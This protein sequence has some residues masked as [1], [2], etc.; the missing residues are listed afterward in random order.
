LKRYPQSILIHATIKRIG[1]MHGG[2]IPKDAEALWQKAM[3]VQK[4]AQEAQAREEALCG[5]EC[6]AELLRRQEK[7][8][9]VHALADEMKTSGQGTSLLTLSEAAARHG[10][11]SEGLE[12]TTS[13]LAKQPLPAI[14]F[15]YPGHFVLVEAVSAKSVKFWNPDGE[16]VGKATTNEMSSTD[17]ERSFSGKVLVLQ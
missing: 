8:V 10:L 13:E 9:D 17:W 3:Q 16:G 14:A 2:D 15:L 12:L 11:K 4:K 6:L 7:S 1:R 5:P